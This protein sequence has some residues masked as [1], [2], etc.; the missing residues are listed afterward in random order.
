[1]QDFS[2]LTALL[3]DSDKDAPAETTL[4]EPS[5]DMDAEDSSNQVFASAAQEAFHAIKQNDAKGFA[6]ALKAAL[7]AC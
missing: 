7:G 2:N 6:E 4:K 3:G 1:M 5:D